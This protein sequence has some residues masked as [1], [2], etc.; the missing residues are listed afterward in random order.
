M[1]PPR[2]EEKAIRLPSGDHCGDSSSWVETMCSRAGA[3]GS[4]RQMLVS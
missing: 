3:P 2:F 4:I 1:R